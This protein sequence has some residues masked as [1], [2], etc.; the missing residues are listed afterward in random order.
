MK[1]VPVIFDWME[2]E[3]IDPDSGEARTTMAMVPQRR[4]DNLAKAQYS[5]EHDYPL[6][7]SE[8]RSKASH[9]HYFASLKESWL[10][11]PHT[12]DWLCVSPEHLRQWCLIETG[13]CEQEQFEFK[14]ASAAKRFAVF[15][16]KRV[17]FCRYWLNGRFLTI[18]NAVSQDYASMDKATFESSKRDVLD[19]C[20]AL[21]G[22]KPAE[23]KKNAGRAA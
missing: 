4:F 9:G 15:Y 6:I 7:P 17:P 5:T 1:I 12:L 14:N 19:M 13:W 18:K 22:V 11:L 2:V 23:L 3:I 20:S 8:T 10:N 16:S 21:L